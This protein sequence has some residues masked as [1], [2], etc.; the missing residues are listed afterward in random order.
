[1]FGNSRQFFIMR[2]NDRAD[3]HDMGNDIAL[4]EESVPLPFRWGEGVRRTGE[5]SCHPLPDHEP[6]QKYSPFTYLHTDCA[7][8]LCGTVHNV[9]SPEMLTQFEPRTL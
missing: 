4:A 9:A 1:V 3:L 5:G 6:G 8:N 7:R 2:Q